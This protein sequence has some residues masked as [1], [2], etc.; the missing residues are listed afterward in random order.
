MNQKEIIDLLLAEVE[1]L[2]EEP[3]KRITYGAHIVAVESRKMGLATWA[4]GK[5]PVSTKDLPAAN[6][7]GSA[8]ELARLLY[9]DNPLKSSL[10]IAAL[11]SLLPDPAAKNITD[12]NAG[13]LIMDLGKGKNVVV[14]GHFPFVER[15]RNSFNDFKVFEKKPQAG[16]FA[17]ELMPEYLPVAD[18]V[19]ITATTIS[20]Q[21]L[22][23]ILNNCSAAAIKLIIGPSTPLTP[24]MFK[25]GFKY[26]AGTLVKDEDTVRME[27]ENGLAFKQVQGVRHVILQ[28]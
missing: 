28:K 18:V 6:K 12:V 16:D 21:S 3:V 27:I 22:A 5:H 11:N 26:V 10:G 23:A 20:N 14:V 13:D 17:A 4:A 2:P 24:I 15:M 8:Q 19:A 7:A 25:L 9:D 1:N